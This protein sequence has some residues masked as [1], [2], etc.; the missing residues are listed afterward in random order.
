VQYFYTEDDGYAYDPDAPGAVEW[1]TEPVVSGPDVNWSDDAETRKVGEAIL[2]HYFGRTATSDE[3]ATF[4]DEI[5]PTIEDGIPLYVEVGKL[6][7]AGL[8]R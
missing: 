8:R 5:A 3:L 1:L 2:R 6:D 4:M 7:D